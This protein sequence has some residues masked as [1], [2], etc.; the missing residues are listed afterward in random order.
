MKIGF[1]EPNR[2]NLDTFRWIV[3]LT[4][5]SSDALLPPAGRVPTLHLFSSW[6]SFCSDSHRHY[7]PSSTQQ[8]VWAQSQRWCHQWH[9]WRPAV[10]GQSTRSWRRVRKLHLSCRFCTTVKYNN[11]L[12]ITV[13]LLSLL[14][15]SSLFIFIFI[16]IIIITTIHLFLL[17]FALQRKQKRK[18]RKIFWPLQFSEYLSHCWNVSE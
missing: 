1:L 3:P 4:H 5:S 15:P 17:S 9:H 8:R 16:M 13:L 2:I 14:L 10:R 11:I 12:F 7:S 6:G 18:S